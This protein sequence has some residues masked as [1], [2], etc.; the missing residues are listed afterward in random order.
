[1]HGHERN[2]QFPGNLCRKTVI[3]K[4]RLPHFGRK[5]KRIELIVQ[6]NGETDAGLFFQ[7]PEPPGGKG[8]LLEPGKGHVHFHEGKSLFSTE[9]SQI[10]GI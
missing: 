6:M 7:F 3:L 10:T 4:V 8:A 1:M 9:M 2:V 5:F